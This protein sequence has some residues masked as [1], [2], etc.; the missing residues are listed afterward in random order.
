MNDSTRGTP[1]TL[2]LAAERRIDRACLEFEE[3]WQSGEQPEME[4]YLTSSSGSERAQLLQELLL[5]ELDY[6]SRAGQ[7]PT[8]EAYHDRFPQDARLIDEVFRSPGGQPMPGTRI[9][10]FGDYQL[11]EEIARGGM[12]IVYRARQLSL[13]RI[14]AL[15][16]V[17]AGRFASE[18]EVQRFRMEAEAAANLQHPNIVAIYE[19]G[20]YDGQQ[21]FSMAHVEGR[22]LAEMIRENPLPAA[23]AAGYVATVAEAVEYAHQGFPFIRCPWAQ[24]SDVQSRRA[25]DR[26]RVQYGPPTGGGCGRV[27]RETRGSVS[28]RRVFDPHLQPEWSVDRHWKARWDDHLL[29]LEWSRT[30]RYEEHK[31]EVWDSRT[32]SLAQTLPTPGRW[33]TVLKFSMDDKHLYVGSNGG[34]L[35]RHDVD[36]GKEI[37]RFSGHQLDVRAVAISPHEKQIIS[38]DIAGHTVIWDV[39]SNQPLLTLLREP[40]TYVNSLDWSSDNRYIAA[41]KSDG[42]VQ[43][44]KLPT[45]P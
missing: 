5:L 23:R 42:T 6:R 24:E 45:A 3:A 28:R 40:G 11:L 29:E 13:N 26:R 25:L 20:Q 7:Q 18:E 36:S 17:L 8:A 38:S 32:K 22:S 37:G 43:I 44:W 12:G 15:K 2:P 30:Q 34:Q 39:D 27:D 31:V 21:Y 16:L 14:V 9:R 33:P 10:Y 1:D 4:R 35:T 19:V 41:G